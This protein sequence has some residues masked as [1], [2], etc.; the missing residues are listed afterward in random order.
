MSGVAGADRI[1]SRNDFKQFLASYQKLIA[2]F[3]GF[4]SMNTSGSY[5]SDL[6]KNDFGDIDLIIHLKS[7]KDK[8]AVKKELQA[9]LQ[10]QPDTVIVP[11]TSEKHAGKRS[12]NA[13]ELV[14]IRYH[15]DTLGYSAQIDNIIITNR[16]LS[17]LPDYFQN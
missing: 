16:S 12:Y 4:V 13:G 14:S 3:P 11:F 7:D 9:F 5:N 6:N 1:K 17:P 10:A 2:K 15:D 8:A